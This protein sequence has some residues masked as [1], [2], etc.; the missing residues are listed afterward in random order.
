VRW[1]V[2]LQMRD[3]ERLLGGGVGGSGG[4]GLTGGGGGGGGGSSGDDP[5]GGG[6]D[7]GEEPDDD[8]SPPGGGVE[9]DEYVL[10]DWTRAASSFPAEI[11]NTA[12]TSTFTTHNIFY[13]EGSEVV[14]NLLL[15]AYVTTDADASGALLQQF[16][17]LQFATQESF[18][19]VGSTSGAILAALTDGTQSGSFT[20]T[21]TATE[22]ITY[23]MALISGQDGQITSDLAAGAGTPSISG[24]AGENELVYVF[25][26][27]NQTVA[28]GGGAGS[29]YTLLS[30]Q[31][32]GATGLKINSGDQVGAVNP[33]DWTAS[34]SGAQHS[35]TLGIRFVS[36]EW[37]T[38]PRGEGVDTAA[39]WVGGNRY[40]K[41]AFGTSTVSTN[42]AQGLIAMT[43][44]NTTVSM[45][46][47]SDS[48]DEPR[49][50]PWGPWADGD[51]QLRY[52][53]KVNPLGD[54]SDVDENL[55][56][57]QVITGGW[58]ASFRVHLGDGATYTYQSGGDERGIVILQ[59]FSAVASDFVPK[60]L[61]ADTYYQTRLDFRGT[62]ARMKLWADGTA[63]PVDWDIDVAKMD[64]DLD[65]PT[66]ISHLILR[67]YG[68]TGMTFTF[69]TSWAQ[70][71]GSASG[72]V[73]ERLPNGD[74]VTTTWTILPWVGNIAVY[75]DG[76]VTKLASF[77]REAGTITFDRAPAVGARIKVEYVPS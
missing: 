28:G 30:D 38:I 2:T 45:F 63:E 56:E 58:R 61:V 17:D 68:N 67:A 66:D 76:I 23:R 41:V 20:V 47:V 33:G 7:G 77:D 35:A 69:D 49:D 60:T 44:D 70:V 48:P 8:P 32:S 53:W 4:S 74:G 26:F 29:G 27:D 1:K 39:P 19:N 64:D 16:V 51:A 3:K 21:T 72:P 50:D 5:A 34:G 40:I 12:G 9:T 57:W 18:S 25:G 15:L 71:G 14:G 42:G 31:T 62:R 13:P 11:E 65:P 24:W 37:G 59:A 75:V 10:D 54:T 52:K 43:A 55:L 73:G 46:L 22:T 36:P 6:N